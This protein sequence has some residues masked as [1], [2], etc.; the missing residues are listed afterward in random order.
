MS[1]IQSKH[2]Q[3]FPAPYRNVIANN[4]KNISFNP[5]SK[6]FTEDNLTRLTRNI[7]S[8]DSYIISVDET[9]NIY[10]FCIHGYYFKAKL[11]D[12]IQAQN[13]T[14]YY[15]VIGVNIIGTENDFTF[16]KSMLYEKKILV[17]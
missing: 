5:E 16:A 8:R 15:A 1:K 13:S 17:D 10:E 6:L 14:T 7:I 12:Y 4:G 9:S 11:S 2:I 3:V